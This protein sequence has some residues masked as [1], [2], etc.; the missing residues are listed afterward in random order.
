M[1]DEHWQNLKQI[2]HAALAL[3]VAER[4]AFISESSQ[5]DESLRRS[6]ESLLKSHEETNNFL[7]AP[8][9]AAAAEM[10]VDRAELRNGQLVAHYKI[11][12]LLGEGGMGRVYLA[13][14]TKLHRRVCLKFL[15]ARFTA[16]PEWL[17]RFEQEARA[18]SA[19]NN[20]NI[21]TIYEIGD[22]DGHRFIATEFIEGNTLRERLRNGI[23]IHTAINLTIQIAAALVAAHRV[24]IVHR[25][26]KPENIMI[27][28]EDGLVKVLD[29]G[30]A[31]MSVDDVPVTSIASEA[32]ADISTTN[33]SVLMGTVAYMSPEQARGE[34][35]DA[36][37][38]I[39]SLGA[40][41]YEIVSGHLPFT[42][43]STN[44]ILSAILATTP[45]P[46]EELESH[47]APSALIDVIAKALNR[48][49]EQR[50]S[51]SPEL[52]ED[53]KVLKESLR[54]TPTIHRSDVA[55]RAAASTAAQSTRV[56]TEERISTAEYLVS[57]VRRHK[58]GAFV[59]AILLLAIAGGF[60]VYGWRA[61]HA[62][63]A[64]SSPQIRSLAVLP[65]KSLDANDNYLGI[66]IADAVIRKIGQTG[67]LTVRPTSAVLKYAKNDIDS[68]VAARELGADAILEGTVQRGGDRLRVTVNLVRIS[69]GSSLYSDNFDLNAAD[70]FAIQD[71]VAQQVAARLQVGFDAGQQARLNERYTPNPKAYESYIRGLGTLDERGYGADAMPEMLDTFESFKRS[72]ELDPTYPL[73]HAKLAFAYA[74]TAVF[75][76]P[77]NSKWAELAREEIKQAQELDPNLAET[78]IAHAFLLWTAYEGYQNEAAIRELLLAKQLD[79]NTSTGDLPAI[80]GHVGLD[81]LASRELERAQQ[82]DPT[83]PSLK[84][85]KMILPYLRGDAEAYLVE[86]QKLAGAQARLAPWYYLRKGLLDQAQKSLDD[87]LRNVP[88]DYNL[89]MKQ[90]LLLALKG[91]FPEAESKVP[92][93]LA[94][95]SV[96][97]NNRHHATYD[98]ACI[99]ALA[100]NSH[101]AVKWLKETAATGFPDY[102][103]FARD[104]FLNRIRQ[105]PEFIQFM[106]EQRAEWEKYREEFGN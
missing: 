12:S 44:E 38:D 47:D 40:V 69:D 2:F 77:N 48:H 10:L 6:L 8:A 73:S 97:N 24:N 35:V 55:S 58:S 20:P 61:K 85:L 96:N 4:G 65:F 30:L 90:A 84:E 41:L 93:I 57:Q 59:A 19:L 27:R 50:Y 79:P 49:K 17:R 88:D 62:V 39:W 54:A 32:H 106:D 94:R 68:T 66:G 67:K 75:I 63:A 18:A 91:S 3:P 101:E 103:L 29:F 21:L 89:M 36:R 60:A 104:P 11:V 71:K 56:D 72:I 64:T 9:Y 1:P 81:D 82:I 80:L 45:L 87:A 105:A 76:E 5:G 28:D 31:K 98:A 46:V 102:P 34:E 22:A 86:R 52:L 51:S 25:D 7:D 83:S 23:D 43:S 99:Y 70:V 26:I 53:L 100:G 33:P 14:D 16:N 42:G 15:S 95:I 78:H 13:E 37:T 74:W 92:E